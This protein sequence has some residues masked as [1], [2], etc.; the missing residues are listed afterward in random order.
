MC[1]FPGSNAL[2]AAA[3]YYSTYIAHYKEVECFRVSLEP[4][5]YEAGVNLVFSG[6]SS[7]HRLA[8]LK[9]PY[10]WVLSRIAKLSNVQS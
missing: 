9:F 10:Y 3:P 7:R 2:A 8:I 6:D 5:L 1:F 4:L